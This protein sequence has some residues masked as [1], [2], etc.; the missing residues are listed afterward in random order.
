[1][2]NETPVRARSLRK[3]RAIKLGSLRLS[4]YSKKIH[5]SRRFQSNISGDGTIT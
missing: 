2:I 3:P 4:H 5:F 1:M